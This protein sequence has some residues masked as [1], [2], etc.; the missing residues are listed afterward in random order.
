M[1]FFLWNRSNILSEVGWFLLL[2]MVPL[3]QDLA[4]LARQIALMNFNIHSKTRSLMSFVLQKP[5][6]YHLELESNLVGRKLPAC[7]ALILH[8]DV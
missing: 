2:T 6:Q 3:L 7:F 5:T 1:D 4:C 8:L